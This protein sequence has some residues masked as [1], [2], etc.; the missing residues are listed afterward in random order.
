MKNT[1]QHLLKRKRA[2]SVGYGDQY[3]FIELSAFAVA[4]V[5]NTYSLS[6]IDVE[7]RYCDVLYLPG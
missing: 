2:D 3:I 6:C 4:D 5:H 1:T 7:G